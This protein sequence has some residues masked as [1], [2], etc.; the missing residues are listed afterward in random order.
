MV[1]S[2]YFR[3]PNGYVVK[4]TAKSAAHDDMTT[5]ATSGEREILGG[6]EGAKL[7]SSGQHWSGSGFHARAGG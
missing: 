1:Q 2:I 6:C 3:D 5:P 7:E 4:L